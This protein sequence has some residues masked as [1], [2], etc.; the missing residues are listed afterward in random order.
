MANGLF[1]VI[2]FDGVPG[3]EW[4]MYKYP[5][6]E[7]F[8]KSTLIVGVGQVA[9]AVHGGKIENIFASGTYK[10]S[11]E[12]FPFLRGLVKAVHGG[13]VPYTMEIY[14]FNT[15]VSLKN[16]WGTQAPV[17]M[18][19]PKFNV[20]VRVRANGQ[21]ALKLEDYQLFFTAVTG[22]VGDKVLYDFGDINN[23]FRGIIN[24]KISVILGEYIIKNRI[25]FL[26]ISLYLNEIS[27]LGKLK[28]E[29][30]FKNYGLRVVNFYF[31]SVNVPEDDLARINEY[32][33]K[34]AEFEIMG[35]DRYR[36]ARGFDVL[37]KAA[38]NNGAAGALASAGVGLGIG[39]GIAP[40]IGQAVQQS[41]AGGSFCSHC[42]K[43][44]PAGAN[45]CPYCGTAGALFCPSCKKEIS[46]GMLFCPFCGAKVK[47]D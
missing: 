14:F 9:I 10:L 29:A 28:I 15:T 36:V 31:S 5:G 47:G 25:S 46:K 42:G 22:S 35:D 6:N 1:N 21:Y 13:N 45:F 39:M 38:E 23:L 24:T 11:T 12:N 34:R 17:Q 44:I 7:F 16:V 32:L 3:R 40:A 27:E 33:N 2:K 19:D 26:D 41:A 43:S 8:D 18:I 20:K 30:E 37:E 4:I